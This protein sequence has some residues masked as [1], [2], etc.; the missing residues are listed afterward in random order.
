MNT[1]A[2]L[3][4]H[5]HL[6]VPICLLCFQESRF[7]HPPY[8][9]SHRKASLCFSVVWAPSPLT[10][11][12]IEG[13]CHRLDYPTDAS[14]F[15]LCRRILLSLD[16]NVLTLKK[17][18]RSIHIKTQAIH[19]SG[20]MGNSGNTGSLPVAAVSLCWALPLGGLGQV[21]S[22]PPSSLLGL[23]SLWVG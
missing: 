17:K 12:T 13:A 21:L 2:F 1:A 6:H 15:R 8:P 14:T 3:S 10:W 23:P 7:D 4:D 11:W 18:V 9:R 16:I 19:F 22:R 5:G 20:R